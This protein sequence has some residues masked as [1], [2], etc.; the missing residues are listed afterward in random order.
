MKYLIGNYHEITWGNIRKYLPKRKDAL[1]LDAGGGTGYWAIRLAKQGYRVVLTDIAKNMLKIAERK[2]RKEKLEKR[3]EVIEVDIRDM[4]CFSSNYFDMALAEGDPVSYCLDAE[5]AVKE[6]TR[7][8]KPNSY[9]IVSVDNKYS[10]ISRLIKD[11]AFDKIS[12]FL[13]TGILEEEFKFQ[14]FTPE[15]L[16]KLFETCELK[17]VRIIGKPILTQLIPMEKKDEI[18]EKNFREILKL[19]LELCDIPSIV[20]FGG[21]LEIVG[22]KQSR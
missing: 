5:K 19:E 17:V 14:A 6:L 16:K 2:I 21:H 12:N 22:V 11:Y 4:C 18:I 3:V 15:E 20:G 8:V 9:V 1:I 13:K 10:F 7:V